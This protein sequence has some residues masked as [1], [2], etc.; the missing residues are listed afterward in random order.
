MK[1][2]EVKKKKKTSHIGFKKNINPSTFW[3]TTN[4]KIQI[5]VK[6]CQP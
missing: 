1:L 2:S 6:I 4:G 3:I 5:F